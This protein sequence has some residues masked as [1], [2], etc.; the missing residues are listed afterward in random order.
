[1]IPHIYS[2]IKQYSSYNLCDVHKQYTK[3]YSPYDTW[4]MSLSFKA[5]FRRELICRCSIKQI[6]CCMTFGYVFNSNC[7]ALKLLPERY[8]FSTII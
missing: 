4:I 7:D 2:N 1:M 6:G 3:N 5:Y 8:E